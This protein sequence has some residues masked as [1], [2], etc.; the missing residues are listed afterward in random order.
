MLNIAETFQN[1]MKQT[2]NDSSKDM[3]K[4]QAVHFEHPFILIGIDLMVSERRIYIDCTKELWSEEQLSAF[5]KWRGLSINQEFFAQLGPLREKNFLVISQEIEE[6]EEIFE[7]ILQNLVDHILSGEDKPLFTTIYE[8]LDRWHNFFLRKKDFRLTPEE[9]RGV[10]GELYYIRKWLGTF[11]DEPPLIISYWKGPTKN[12]IDFVKNDFAV[13]IKTIVPKIRE[14][15]KIANEK[16]LELNPVINKLYLY[17]IEIEPNESDGKTIQQLMDEIRQILLIKAPSI[18]VKF[19]DLLLDLGITDEIYNDTLYFVHKENAY[20]VTS[21]FPKITS[22]ILPVGVS[23]VSYSI[24]LSH[25]INFQV[26]IDR[27]Y[28]LNGGG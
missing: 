3:Y 20:K 27:V 19:N 16:Q 12:R 6:S 24:D 5:P 17:V 8:V 23:N 2:E 13:E 14:D 25:C 7:K 10:F 4:L 15:V 26:S 1:L 11:P 22:D 28:N 18:L 9:Q 21:D